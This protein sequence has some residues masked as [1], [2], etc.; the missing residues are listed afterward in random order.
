MQK[1]LTIEVEEAAVERISDEDNVGILIIL[2]DGTH[3]LISSD[4]IGIFSE[5]TINSPE[6][7]FSNISTLS[8]EL[9]LKESLNLEDFPNVSESIQ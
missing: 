1:L 2:K 7:N 8:L 3:I 5:K 6:M 4:K 9:Y